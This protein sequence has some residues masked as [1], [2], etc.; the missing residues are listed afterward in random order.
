MNEI[1]IVD[2]IT[3]QGFAIAVCVYLLYERSKGN[4]VMVNQFSDALDSM[5]K[6]LNEI[7]VTLRERKVV[8]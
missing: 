7:V 2:I 4:S 8:I 3:N 6:Q 5:T 1:E